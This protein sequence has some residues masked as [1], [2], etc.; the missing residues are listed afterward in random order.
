MFG[1]DEAARSALH[2]PEVAEWEDGE[3]LASEREVLGFYVSGHPLDDHKEIIQRFANIDTLRLAEVA[4]ARKLK[5]AGLIRSSRLR[6]TR[7][8]RRMANFVLEDQVGTAEM[9]L[10]P[11]VFENCHEILESEE[12]VLVEGVAEVSDDGV[13][14]VVRAIELLSGVEVNHASRVLV[15]LEP[16]CRTPNRLQSIREVLARHPGNCAVLFT[17]RF[18]GREVR[19]EAGQEYVVAPTAELTDELGDLVGA[20]AVH[21]E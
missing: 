10:F 11:D 16:E 20:G 19:I 21:F 8:G 4:S 15:D 2:L 5:M 7:A 1:G 6:T 12:P 13:Q 18:P 9:T 3:R 17:L 14:V